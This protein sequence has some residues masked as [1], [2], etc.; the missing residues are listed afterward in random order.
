MS[1]ENLLNTEWNEAQFAGDYCVTE[2][3]EAENGLI[4][5]PGTPFFAKGSICINF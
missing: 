1:V 5:T 3:V 4:F 2:T